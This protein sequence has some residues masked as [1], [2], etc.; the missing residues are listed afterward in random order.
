MERDPGNSQIRLDASRAIQAEPG[1]RS[2]DDISKDLRY[3]DRLQQ[4]HGA[5]NNFGCLFYPVS[6]WIYF[7]G[8]FEGRALSTTSIVAALT[9]GMCGTVGS[10]GIWMAAFVDIYKRRQVLLHEKSNMESPLSQS[11]EEIAPTEKVRDKIR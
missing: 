8:M 7:T 10:F 11:M 2:L 4:A 5:V 1:N 3:L 9:V 6:S